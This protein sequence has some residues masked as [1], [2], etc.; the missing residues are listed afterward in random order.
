MVGSCCQTILV[1]EDGDHFTSVFYRNRNCDRVAPELQL[2]TIYY[3][4]PPS[5]KSGIHKSELQCLL[6]G[7]TLTADALLRADLQHRRS[8]DRVK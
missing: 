6:S 5:V 2:C 7:A 8:D 3:W 1:L 4:E